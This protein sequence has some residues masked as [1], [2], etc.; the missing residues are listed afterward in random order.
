MSSLIAELSKKYTPPEFAKIFKP[1]TRGAIAEQIG[2]SYGLTSNILSGCRKP[3]PELEKRFIALAA[4]IEFE[5]RGN[6]DA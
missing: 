3:S 6:A 2:L 4:Q 5:I 1:Y